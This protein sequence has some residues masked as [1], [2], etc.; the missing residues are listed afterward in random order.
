MVGGYLSFG[1]MNPDLFFPEDWGSGIAVDAGGSAYVSGRAISID[2]PTTAGAF[3][4][5]FG[6]GAD[7]IVAKISA[8]GGMES[9]LSWR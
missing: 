5:T 4:P 7:A 3:Q 8:L 2:F 1:S 9:F 6:G